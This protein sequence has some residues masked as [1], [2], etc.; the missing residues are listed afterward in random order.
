MRER[1]SI[2]GPRELLREQSQQPVGAA[3]T[4]PTS[5][6]AA[7]RALPGGSPLG[8]APPPGQHARTRSQAVTAATREPMHR[9]RGNWLGRPPRARHSLAARRSPSRALAALASPMARA[10]PQ[11]LIFHG[12]TR[13]LSGGRGETRMIKATTLT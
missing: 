10:P 5:G 8:A 1:E 9:D 2:E 11:T 12:K 13:R 6:R 3:G 4:A 7:C